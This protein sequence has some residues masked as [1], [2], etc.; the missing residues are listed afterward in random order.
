M[1]TYKALFPILEVVLSCLAGLAFFMGISFLAS[2]LGSNLAFMVKF[3][4]YYL[5]SFLPTHIVF[6][7]H[8]YVYPRSEKLQRISGMT[9]GAIIATLGFLTTLLSAVYVM[10]GTYS[11]ILLR[12]PTALFP[13]DCILGGIVFAFLGGLLFFLAIKKK[14]PYVPDVKEAK[15]NL[16]TKIAKG[17]SYPLFVL[18]AFN[19][20]GA[21]LTVPVTFDYSWSTWFTMIPVYLLLC[22]PFVMMCLYYFGYKLA[23]P[24]KK[25]SNQLIISAI[26]LGLGIFLSMYLLITEHFHPD[27][28]ASIAVA[29]FP[30]DGVASIVL[31]P[32]SLIVLSVL[33]PFLSLLGT[34]F[35]GRSHPKKAKSEK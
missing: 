7:Y 23:K 3:L 8:C 10:N 18:F 30:I 13:L 31:G 12:E 11:S 4:P 20:I 34:F 24:E 26:C 28:V 2:D 21:F 1:K 32:I 14:L 9:N 33:P 22:Y 15:N 25:K 5:A 16:A 17:I 29:Y 27:F 19:Y 35:P 6:A